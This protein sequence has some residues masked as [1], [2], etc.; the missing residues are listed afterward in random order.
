MAFDRVNFFISAI[1]FMAF[2]N[3]LD[4]DNL[5]RRDNCMTH[6]QQ[7]NAGLFSAISST[8]KSTELLPLW[9]GVRILDG[10]PENYL[11]NDLVFLTPSLTP[12]P[13]NQILTLRR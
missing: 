2:N 3:A 13:Y 5:L 12:P 1:V 9:F 8:G 6:D 10:G 7:P 4:T 11:I